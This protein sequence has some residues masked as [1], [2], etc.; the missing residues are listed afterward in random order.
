[1]DHEND[2]HAQLA[3]SDVPAGH[4]RFRNITITFNEQQNI[5]EV[6]NKQLSI[7]SSLVLNISS[8][9]A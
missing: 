8:G 1:M 4:V 3:R 5:L 2:S 9:N 6:D 7:G